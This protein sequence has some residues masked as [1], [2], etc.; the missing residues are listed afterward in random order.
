MA[1]SHSPLVITSG[2]VLYLDAANPRSYPGSGTTWFDLSGNGNNGTLT[3]GPVFN[4]ANGGVISFDGVN[5]YIVLTTNVD[6]TLGSGYTLSIWVKFNTIVSQSLWSSYNGQGASDGI[7]M[8]IESGNGD[9]SNFLTDSGGGNYMGQISSAGA[10]SSGSWFNIVG[11]WRGSF[12]SSSWQIFVNGI[13]L[14]T[15]NYS[16]GTVNSFDE[17]TDP[18]EIGR[19]RNFAGPTGYLNGL[20]SIAQVYNRPLSNQEIRQNFNA[21]RGR[22]GI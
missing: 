17:S 5:D 21:T 9:I 20:V 4:S 10:V 6:N 13:L 8:G 7:T 19:Y 14:S 2:L 3:N 11:T 16:G 1:L 18:L 15:S 12:V 22:F